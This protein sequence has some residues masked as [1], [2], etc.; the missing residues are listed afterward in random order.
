MTTRH[1]PRPRPA[2]RRPADDHGPPR[3]ELVEGVATPVSRSWAH[4]AAI[5]SL[6]RGLAA[7]LAALGLVAGSGD[8]DLPGSA[9]RYVPGLAVVPAGL[10]AST[11]GALLPHHTLL[12]VEV[13]SPSTADSDRAVKR[14]RYGQYG[15]PLYL[16]VDRQSRT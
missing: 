8:L 11:E 14:R 2:P 15:T 1:R 3:T 12:V 6:R 10:A 16:L 5:A 9:N 7:R 13:T 4:E